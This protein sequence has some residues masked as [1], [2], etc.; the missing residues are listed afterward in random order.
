MKDDKQLTGILSKILQSLLLVYMED[1]MVNA[2][3]AQNP[4]IAQLDEIMQHLTSRVTYSKGAVKAP[5]TQLLNIVNTE[6]FAR[7]ENAAIKTKVLGLVYG[8]IKGYSQHEGVAEEDA[9]VFKITLTAI[10]SETLPIVHKCRYY[11]LC[12][13]RMKMGY[14]ATKDVQ[15]RRMLTDKLIELFAA[16]FSLKKAFIHFGLLLVI[17]MFPNWQNTLRPL[18]TGSI[19]EYHHVNTKLSEV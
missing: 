6:E 3:L 17:A 7:F 15:D 18:F 1:D 11:I 16:D 5:I 9:E 8:F 2:N 19:M 14:L 12:L 13:H 10:Q 4:K